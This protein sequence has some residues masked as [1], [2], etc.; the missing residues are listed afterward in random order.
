MKKWFR[1]SGTVAALAA[2]SVLSFAAVSFAQA[3][4]PDAQP[5]LVERFRGGMQEHFGGPGG[6]RG[7]RGGEMEGAHV[8]QNAVLAEALGMTEDELQAARDAGQTLT[9]I[10]EAQGVDLD[11]LKA[12]LSAARL[13]AMKS[14]LADKVAAGDITQAQADAMLQRME[15]GDLL[16]KGERGNFG[17]REMGNRD[18]GQLPAE[19]Q[20]ALAS[21]LNMSV[22]DLQA[23]I[24]DGQTLPEIAEAQ[25]VDMES[26]KAA[27]TAQR[28]AQLETTLAEKVAAGDIT[29]AQAD[30]ILERAQSGDFGKRGGMKGHPG[31]RGGR[32]FP[33][34]T[35]FQPSV[36]GDSN[37]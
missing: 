7:M 32:S 5:G 6:P 11:T 35:N 12:D 10:A 21:A 25:G 24:D 3:E 28:L 37:L 15:N 27:M 9:E 22:E 18:F 17:G 29:Q 16:G 2:L 31:G 8:E 14:Q 1:I 20:T 36:T 30:A 4:T 13:E 33:G 23:A 34:G 19:A 26:V